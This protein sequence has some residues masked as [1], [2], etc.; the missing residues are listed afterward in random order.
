MHG[1]VLRIYKDRMVWIAASLNSQWADVVT[2]IPSLHTNTVPD[3]VK[4]WKDLHHHFT[5][6][7]VQEVDIIDD[8]KVKAARYTAYMH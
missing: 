2:M 8:L 3:S 7:H 1:E 4:T 6:L 5:D